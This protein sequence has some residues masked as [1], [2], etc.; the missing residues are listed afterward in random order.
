LL[1][2]N[3]FQRHPIHVYYFHSNR[4]GIPHL[5]SEQIYFRVNH[6]ISNCRAANSMLNN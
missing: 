5:F 6:G 3:T 4:Q 2:G 1:T